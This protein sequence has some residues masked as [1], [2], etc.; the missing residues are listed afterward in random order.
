MTLMN[1]SPTPCGACAVVL[2]DHDAHRQPVWRSINSCLVPVN[3]LQGR[4]LL[5]PEGIGCPSG[6]QALHPT[7]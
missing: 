5:T 7:R 2:L 6:I 1:V 4:S 3:T